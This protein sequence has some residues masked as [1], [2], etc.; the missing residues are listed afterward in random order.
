M[1]CHWVP[2]NSNLFEI[3]RVVYYYYYYIWVCEDFA[4]EQAAHPPNFCKMYELS[5]TFTLTLPDI[6]SPSINLHAGWLS[7]LSLWHNVIKC[8]YPSRAS[9]SLRSGSPC[10][11][12]RLAVHAVSYPFGEVYRGHLIYYRSDANLLL[13]SV[14]RHYVPPDTIAFKWTQTPRFMV[15]ILVTNIPIKW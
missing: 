11:C 7:Q 4:G 15:R 3:L 10:T 2:R 6:G 14:S 8:C 5:S 9:Q 13:H 12:Y 1:D